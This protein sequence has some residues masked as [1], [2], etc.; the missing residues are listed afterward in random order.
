MDKKLTYQKALQELEN[1]LQ[2]LE[3]QEIPIDQLA[4][5]VKYAYELLQYCQQKLKL[6][7]DELQNRFSTSK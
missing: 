3:N 4:D 1:L 6:T 2:Q 7:E 5:K